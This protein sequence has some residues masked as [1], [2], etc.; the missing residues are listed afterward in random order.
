[1][2]CNTAILAVSLRVP[3]NGPRSIKP[4]I[5]PIEGQCLA[6]ATT[7]QDEEEDQGPNVGSRQVDEPIDLILG[8]PTL[9]LVVKL[10]V[11]EVRYVAPPLLGRIIQNGCQ[12]LDQKTHNRRGRIFLAITT[13]LKTLLL[14]L[15]QCLLID[16][17]HQPITEIRH[18]ARAP[19]AIPADTPDDRNELRPG[20]F[21]A[22]DI[23]ESRFTERMVLLTDQSVKE[24]AV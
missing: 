11:A 14:D 16:V 19:R 22:I 20:R 23:R 1:M 6:L 7:L 4:N 17:L 13:H 5:Y 24:I 3:Q 8:R 9:A 10:R 21:D 18:E 12:R 2:E 15:F